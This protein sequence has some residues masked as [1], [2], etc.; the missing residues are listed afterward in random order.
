MLKKIIRRFM[1]FPRI[2]RFMLE[3]F[4][5]RRLG[6]GV[7]GVNAVLSDY[8]EAAGI[9]GGEYFH[10]DLLVAGFIFQAKPK[11]HIDIGSRIDGFVAHV[12]SYREI[13]VF[14]IRSISNNIHENIIFKQHDFMGSLSLGEEISDSVSSLHSIEHFGLGRYGD[15]IDPSGHI[16]GFRNIARIVKRGGVLYLSLPVGIEN[17]TEFNAQRTF[18]ITE[19]F[20]WMDHSLTFELKRLDFIDDLGILHLNLQIPDIAT[21]LTTGC[22]IYTLRRK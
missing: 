19:L 9:T 1:L 14:D 6:G 8:E 7:S 2:L 20:S 12:A 18:T 5:F 3:L 11:R 17:R 22:A 15:R 16:K 21:K 13:E 10:Q 4:E